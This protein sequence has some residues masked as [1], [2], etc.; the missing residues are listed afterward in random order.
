MDIIKNLK[1]GETISTSD[2]KIIDKNTYF[3][4]FYRF[5]NNESREKSLE[6]IKDK[7]NKEIYINSNDVVEIKIGLSNMID[8]Y[9][10][11]F[12]FINKIITVMNKLKDTPN[13]DLEYA[14]S[15][16]EITK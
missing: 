8:T 6:W 14:K 10:D 15:Y 16:A 1:P 3:S 13:V 7:L 4:S 12:D 11:D 5:Y 2:D 9:S